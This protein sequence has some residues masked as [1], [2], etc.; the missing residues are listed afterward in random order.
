MAD[1]NNL[2]N[3]T[4]YET[5]RCFIEAEDWKIVGRNLNRMWGDFSGTTNS[6]WIA[7][8]FGF[9]AVPAMLASYVLPFYFV[10]RLFSAARRRGEIPV[11]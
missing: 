5:Y 9:A 3:L 6:E 4:P 10:A 7:I 8:I 2:S 1:C 11:G